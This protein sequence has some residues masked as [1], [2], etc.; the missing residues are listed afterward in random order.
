MGACMGK[1][2]DEDEQDWGIHGRRGSTGGRAAET[3][4]PRRWKDDA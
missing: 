2:V 3:G 1:D 4:G